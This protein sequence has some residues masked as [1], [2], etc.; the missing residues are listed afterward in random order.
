VALNP[1]Y[2]VVAVIAVLL[3]ISWRRRRHGEAK[4]PDDNGSP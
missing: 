3:V 4:G 1:G 2:L